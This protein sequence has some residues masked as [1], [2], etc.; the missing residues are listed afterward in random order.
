MD[1]GFEPSLIDR[2]KLVLGKAAFV[3]VKGEVVVLK[4]LQLSNCFRDRP[5][6]PKTKQS[7]RSDQVFEHI[8][9]QTAPQ[10]HAKSTCDRYGVTR[11]KVLC[12]HLMRVSRLG[13]IQCIARF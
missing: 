8:P 1:Q 5:Y 3:G 13:S 10:G 2:E 4:W 7:T 11:L 6:V 9:N 12:C